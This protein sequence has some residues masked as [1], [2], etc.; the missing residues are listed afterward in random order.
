MRK[1][2]VRSRTRE[3]ELVPPAGRVPAAVLRPLSSRRCV[4][5]LARNTVAR[6]AFAHRAQVNIAPMLYV[7]VD[8]WLYA[9]ADAAM[10]TAI[11]HNR[12]VAVEVAEVTGVSEW[13]SVVARGACYSTTDAGSTD[14]HAVAEGIA[15]LRNR[16]PEMSRPGSGARFRTAIYRVHVDELTGYSARPSRPRSNGATAQRRAARA[17]EQARA[18]DDGMSQA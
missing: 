3:P 16:I 1:T 18:D 11:R 9:R 14:D 17:R 12:W 2:G 6:I 15:R 8:G 7:F 10:R 5:V 13:Q 4:A